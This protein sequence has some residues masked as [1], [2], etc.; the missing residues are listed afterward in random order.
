MR[1]IPIIG[2]CGINTTSVQCR[3]S[4]RRNFPVKIL[5]LLKM[6]K[7]AG[8]LAVGHIAGVTA[9]AGR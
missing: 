6:T 5:M 3:S 4:D 8:S 1:G 9:E 2:T 7:N